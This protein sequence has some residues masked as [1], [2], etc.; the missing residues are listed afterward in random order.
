[1]TGSL[2]HADL[3]CVLVVQYAEG[4]AGGDISAD[5]DFAWGV[6]ALNLHK[7]YRGALDKILARLFA[8]APPRG[9]LPLLK[10]F[11]VVCLHDMAGPVFDGTVPSAWRAACEA[12]AEL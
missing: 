3:A 6:C 1:M 2:R 12:A 5:V 10:L 8:R 4:R 9:R 7:R 11:D